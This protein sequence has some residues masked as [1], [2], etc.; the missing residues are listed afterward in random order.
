[1]GMDATRRRRWLGGLF[2]LAATAMLILGQ[3]VFERR[4][5]RAVFVIYWLACFGFTG[6]AIFMAFLDVLALQRR[7]REEQR[8]LMQTTLNEIVTDAR[9]AKSEVRNPKSDTRSTDGHR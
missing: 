4:L 9:A 6:M 7:T 1:M 5:S 3:T 8:N 2:L